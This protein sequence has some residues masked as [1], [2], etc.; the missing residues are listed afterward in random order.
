LILRGDDGAARVAQRSEKLKHSFRLATLMVCGP[1]RISGVD[2]E[3]IPIARP[4]AQGAP[5]GRTIGTWNAICRSP[6]LM[7]G[8]VCR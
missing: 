6:R 2:P 8:Y 4:N 7:V 1:I 3:F 5:V